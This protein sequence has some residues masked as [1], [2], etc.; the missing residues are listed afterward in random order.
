[1]AAARREAAEGAAAAAG[2]RPAARSES[3]VFSVPTP[4]ARGTAGIII[5]ILYVER[6]VH[7]HTWITQVVAAAGGWLGPAMPAF[8]GASCTDAP[9]GGR[10]RRQIGQSSVTGTARDI[11]NGRVKAGDRAIEKPTEIIDPLVADN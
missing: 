11:I 7:L 10:L 6:V 2:K 4:C 3:F 9:Q 1:M 8:A 5:N